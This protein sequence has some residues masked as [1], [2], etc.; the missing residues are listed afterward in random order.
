MIPTAFEL[1][2]EAE[3]CIRE[4]EAQ[5]LQWLGEAQAR[6]S[7]QANPVLRMV[8]RSGGLLTDAGRWLEEWKV[9]RASPR[10]GQAQ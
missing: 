2:H 7:S 1:L 9:S 3:W 6:R 5:T 4:R 10:H 8:S